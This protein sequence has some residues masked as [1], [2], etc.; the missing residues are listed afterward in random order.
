MTIRIREEKREKRSKI[1]DV[2]LEE[3]EDAVLLR[4]QVERGMSF[5]LFRLTEKDGKLTCSPYGGLPSDDF[6]VNPDDDTIKV[7][8]TWE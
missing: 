2:Y 3:R 7:G 1:F 4:V 8:E 6:E 5:W